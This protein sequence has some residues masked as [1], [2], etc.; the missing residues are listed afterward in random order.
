MPIFNE[1]LYAAVKGGSVCVLRPCF[2]IT[3]CREKQRQ[4]REEAAGKKRRNTDRV[5]AAEMGEAGS[6]V[7]RTLH[8]ECRI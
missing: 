1:L 7:R 2:V 8:T 3:G 5:M 6:V 4:D